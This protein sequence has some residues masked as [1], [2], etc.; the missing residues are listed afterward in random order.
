M[1]TCGKDLGHKMWLFKKLGPIREKESSGRSWTHWPG[2]EEETRQCH[3]M[4]WHQGLTDCP[5]ES[6][7]SGVQGTE[8]RLK[9][10]KDRI[11]G[12]KTKITNTDNFLWFSFFF[13]CFIFGIL[14][15]KTWKVSGK[16]DYSCGGKSG[17]KKEAL[18]SPSKSR[19]CGR[20][21]Y[22][23]MG[24]INYAP[25]WIILPGFFLSKK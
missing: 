11:W 6:S 20:Y 14:K 4:V 1:Y 24:N 5:D 23:L 13:H 16:W 3:I 22:V 2:Q 25:N 9:W 17:F 10:I 19:H 18:F 7:L 12:K 15:K 8:T 21:V